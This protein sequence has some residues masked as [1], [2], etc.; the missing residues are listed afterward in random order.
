[1]AYK[2]GP[3][4]NVL[5]GASRAIT[6]QSNLVIGLVSIAPKGASNELILINSERSASTMFG[7]A[8]PSN[9]MRLAISQ[10][11]QQTEAA[12]I[13]INVFDESTHTEI[14][15]ETKEVTGGRIV[16]NPDRLY[17]GD[18]EI[19]TTDTVPVPLVLNTDYTFDEDTQVIKI[20]NTVSYPDTTE[21]EI[22]YTAVKTDLNS[23]TNTQI[24]GTVNNGTRTGLELFDNAVAK[25][26]FAPRLLLSPYFSER[27]PVANALIAKAEKIEAQ[28][29]IDIIKAATVTDVLEG[30]NGT[31]G[32]VKNIQTDSTR[33][34]LVYPWVNATMPFTGEVKET[35]YS[36]FVA[37]GIIKGA[38][39]KLS[40]SADNIPL[41]GILSP[42]VL[43]EHDP[44][45]ETSES[46]LLGGAGVL[47]Y[48]QM[49]GTG[50]YTWGSRS[51]AFP[52]NDQPRSFIHVQ[53]VCDIIKT[54][55]IAAAYPY[56][57]EELTKAKIQALLSACNT[58]LRELQTN[59]TLV[60]SPR[61]VVEFLASDNPDS[62][63]AQGHITLRVN[64]VP[65][66]SIDRITFDLY[67]NQPQAAEFI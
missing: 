58:F 56:I 40:R 3:E 31:A 26:G 50:F 53:R 13:C 5:D 62:Q 9:L 18:L 12:I 66:L 8:H 30:R 24:I 60:I 29:I 37:G 52:T 21:L 15:T 51:A 35:P 61:N 54:S 48:R 64:I 49:P 32:V 22:T 55:L 33:A 10:I 59:G 1:M 38:T 57:G 7:N 47:T 25:Y 11:L 23:V 28:A 19:E 4:V 46:N 34:I 2:H 16:L 6:I 65:T 20:I 36:P 44:S 17:Y 14:L 41:L 45:S 27:Q 63:L 39:Q 42:Y 67:V 43:I